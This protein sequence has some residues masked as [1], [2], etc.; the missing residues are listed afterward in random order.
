MKKSVLLCLAALAGCATYV[1]DQ[2]AIEAGRNAS[3]PVSIEAAQGAISAYLVNYLYDPESAQYKLGEPV[4][5]YVSG[6]KG[7]LH[8]WFVCGQINS[9]NRLG[10]YVGFHPFWAYFD[11]ANPGQVITAAVDSGNDYLAAQRCESISA[12]RTDVVWAPKV[13]D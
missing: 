8:G 12:N 5:S 7:G 1:P 10:G 2:A 6:W 9:K 4:N 11:P 3:P 13:Q